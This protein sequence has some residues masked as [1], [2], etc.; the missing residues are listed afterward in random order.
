MDNVLGYDILNEPWGD[1]KSQIGPLFDDAARIIR[2]QDPEAILFLTPQMMH[3][4]GSRTHLERPKFD[5]FVYSAHYYASSIMVFHAWWGESP[6]QTLSELQS[7]ADQWGVPLFLGEFG[8][9]NDTLG[10]VPYIH[11]QYKALDEN[12]IGGT[13]WVY[14][15]GYNPI[16]KDGCNGENLSITDETGKLRNNFKIRPYPMAIAGEPLKGGFMIDLENQKQLRFQWKM[17]EDM[18]GKKTEIFAPKSLFKSFTPQD[19][20]IILRTTPNLHCEY[21]TENNK[22]TCI[23]SQSGLQQLEVLKKKAAY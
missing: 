4:S 17:G 10:I 20:E 5:N 3:S 21:D 9:P 22:I 13:Q 23:A 18:I 16:T 15:P 6:E 2:T 12:L 14:T 11:A 8:G 1:E 19:Q 7:K